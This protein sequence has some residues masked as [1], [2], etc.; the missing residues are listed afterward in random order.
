MEAMREFLKKI[1]PVGCAIFLGMFVLFFGL[2]ISESRDELKGY[3]P[4]QDSAY[5]SAHPAE[6]AAE[7]DTAV[8]PRLEGITAVIYDAETNTVTVSVEYDRFF[9]V[10]RA[11]YSHFDR[12][13][14]EVTQEEET[15]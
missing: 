14:L 1:G 9:P 8:R 4:P 5:Y 2:V 11:I 12:E 15:K 3:E 6:L 7:L 13:L 10:R